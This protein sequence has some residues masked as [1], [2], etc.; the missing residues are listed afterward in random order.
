MSRHG[1]GER[2]RA[3]SVATLHAWSGGASQTR[4][5]QVLAGG[6]AAALLYL[7]RGSRFHNEQRIW[8]LYKIHFNDDTT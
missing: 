5:E 2:V 7:A 3:Q 1:L 4:T 6:L 8:L